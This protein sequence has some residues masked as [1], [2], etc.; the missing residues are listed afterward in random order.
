MRDDGA[1]YSTGQTENK[2]DHKHPQLV[3]HDSPRLNKGGITGVR[4]GTARTIDQT[5]TST[6]V[7]EAT[8]P[9]LVSTGPLVL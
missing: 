8:K 6:L 5:R 9:A 1:H 2:W 3:Y 7:C 4:G